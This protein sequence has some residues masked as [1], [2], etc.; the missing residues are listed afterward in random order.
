[1]KKIIIL[2]NTILFLFPVFA[3]SEGDDENAS[4]PLAAVSN[5]DFKIKYYD[6]ENKSERL[7]YSIDGATMLNPKL[8][9]KY[10]L[11]Y[12]DTDVT[13]NDEKDLESFHL[14]FISFPVEGKL[15]G[16]QPYRLAVGAEWIKDLGDTDKG[17]GTG[18]DQIAPLVGLAVGI[19]PGTMLIP[20]LQHYESYDS[21][22]ISQ[23]ALRLIA[24]QNF[25]NDVWGKMDLK[26]SRDW[27]NDETPTSVEFQLGKSFTKSL[28]LYLDLQ[29]G[30]GSDKSYD[31]AT[32][33][34][35]RFNY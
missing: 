31:F 15:Q 30:F 27:K 33:I 10:E 8:K 6:L 11:N 29:S 18:S 1:M 2:L 4:N 3:F 14:K 24:L 9:L 12:W 35:L 21:G 16:G 26:I 23:T 19:R 28:G 7:E 25:P 34:G 17:I 20:L 5:T 22:D 13:G 32:G